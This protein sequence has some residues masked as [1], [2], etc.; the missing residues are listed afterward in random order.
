MLAGC[1]LSLFLPLLPAFFT[2]IFALL[3]I[4]AAYW[5][6]GLLLGCCGFL[7]SWHWQLTQYH[8]AQQW[9]LQN[10]LDF[11]QVK[12][13]DVQQRS[14]DSTVLLQLLNGKAAGYRL[15][16]SWQQPPALATGQHW[17]LALR[18]KAP[19]GRFNPGSPNPELRALLN[20]V[21]AHGYVN[22]S[23][24]TIKLRQTQPMREALLL[25]LEQQYAA[26]DT[27]VLMR[28]L[29]SGEREFDATLWQ[30]LRTSG[31]GH[32]L[33][34]SGLH[35]SL[36]YGWSLLLL[37]WL[38]RRCGLRQAMNLAMLL[39][40][41]PA[42][43]YA[44][45]AGFAIPTLRAAL[46]LLIVLLGR[47]LLRPANP[48]G[49]WGLLCCSLLLLQPFWLLSYSFW[50]SLS[51]VALI[52]LLLWRLGPA[53]RKFW[54][55]CR[56]F[57]RFHL[58]LTSLMAL[59][60]LAFF[61]G[62]SGLALLSN[63]LF[64]PWC[65]LLA[66]PLLLMCLLYYLTGLPFAGV[67]W[68]L[69]DYAL[70]PLNYWLTLS[71]DLDLWWSQP[72]LGMVGACLLLLLVVAVLVVR[73]KASVLALLSATMLFAVLPA[74]LSSAQ[75]TLLDS[76]QSTVLLVRQPGLTLLYL[77]LPV[78]QGE[79]L[80]QHQVL[81]L[82]AYY[83][84]SGLDAVVMPGYQREMQPALATLRQ[85]YPQLQLYTA[86]A[87]TEE[88]S[89]CGQLAAAYTTAVR[90][91]RLPEQDPCVL[92]IILN[93]WQLLLPGRLSVQSERQLL[94]AYPELTADWYLLADYG[95]ATANSLAFLQQ[96]APVQ[97]LL[98]ANSA[99]AYPYPVQA[100]RPRLGLLNLPLHHSGEQGAVSIEFQPQ[101]FRLHTERQRR[102]PRWTE[103]PTQ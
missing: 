28:A 59:L 27:A 65:T 13:L 39:A 8:H 31:L 79:A 23:Q 56:Y 98:A 76:G 62:F 90:H 96:L 37:S 29:V 44:W 15:K 88:H 61:S 73:A 94:L 66:I 87:A 4:Q 85:A 95:R 26:L 52:L 58:L 57:F 35:I 43:A 68:Q 14:T 17:R 60:T 49:Y 72:Y 48:A 64:V 42:L 102:W 86:A 51:A 40:L 82:L 34:I 83:R 6:N 9:V 78:E 101:Y 5:R 30:G 103:K 25:K 24:P 12:L 1:L 63:L 99:G 70:R 77:D 21:V 67:L 53:P 89:N 80:L 41:L 100:V 36:V 54:Q 46:A 50:L 2:I 91:W 84:V 32:L 7:A 75:L 10:S 92:T 16:V 69:S 74:K 55:R 93:G 11:Y 97:L 47:L 38:L 81:P 18:L 71:A 45:L 19:S 22:T 3:V 33:V 20:Q